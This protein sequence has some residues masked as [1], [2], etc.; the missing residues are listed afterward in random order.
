M[1]LRAMEASCQSLVRNH[2]LGHPD[3]VQ[4][5]FINTAYCGDI[6]IAGGGKQNIIAGVVS[7]I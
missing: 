3:M 6:G 2:H 4:Q 1:E 7:G 5:V